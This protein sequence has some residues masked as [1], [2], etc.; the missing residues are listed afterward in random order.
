MGEKPRQAGEAGSERAAIIRLLLSGQGGASGEG[1]AGGLSCLGPRGPLLSEG[2]PRR[3]RAC[4]Q[5]CVRV[6][7]LCVACKGVSYVC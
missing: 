7:S 2:Q 5:G 1:L 4:A 6:W 3:E